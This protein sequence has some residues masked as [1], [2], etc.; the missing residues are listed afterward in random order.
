M[1]KAVWEL[2]PPWP[3]QAAARAPCAGGTTM[4]PWMALLCHLCSL[5]GL[6]A[7]LP[8]SKIRNINF[9]GL[10][11]R[12]SVPLQSSSS[13]FVLETAPASHL[14]SFWSV[15]RNNCNGKSR[16]SMGSL[17]VHLKLLMLAPEGFPWADWAVV[18]HG[19]SHG[20]GDPF[21]LEIPG[22]LVLLPHSP[23]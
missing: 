8:W 10:S 20:D 16:R 14:L 11:P 21:H 17:C 22:R 18:T 6:T 4:S 15:V 13:K 2:G 3:S 7:S 19:G 9:F 23:R 1:L 5:P 12:V